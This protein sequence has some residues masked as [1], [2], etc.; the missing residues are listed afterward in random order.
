MLGVCALHVVQHLEAP[1]LEKSKVTQSNFTLRVIGHNPNS[2]K[3]QLASVSVRKTIEPIF[4]TSYNEFCSRQRRTKDLRLV[5][6]LM[7]G[8]LLWPTEWSSF[9]GGLHTRSKFCLCCFFTFFC[10]GFHSFC[11]IYLLF[12][13]KHY[14]TVLGIQ[15]TICVS[16][17]SK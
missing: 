4:F 8:F 6:H 2:T 3:F 7:G 9:D 10:L 12:C 11:F 5:A 14:V 17:N 15:T 16:L 13:C 1:V